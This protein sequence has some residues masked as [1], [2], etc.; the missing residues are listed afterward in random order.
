MTGPR[1]AAPRGGRTALPAASAPDETSRTFSIDGTASAISSASSTSRSVDAPK[2]VPSSAASRTASTVSGSACPN[3][4]GPHDC[5]QSRSRRPSSVSTY[6]PS[7]RA[8]KSGSS[9]PT[10]R[11]ARTGELTPPGITFCARCQRAVRT[12]GPIRKSRRVPGLEPAR[13]L[14]RPVRDH[15][16]GARP[17]DRRQRLDRRRALVDVARRSRRL[18]HRVLARHAVRGERQLEALAHRAHDVEVRQRRL[19]HQHIRALRDVELALAERL[20]DVAGIHLVP[21]AVAERRHRAGGVAKRP[22]ERRGVLG[23]VGDDR[24]VGELGSNCRDAPVHHVARTD[25]VRA[26]LHVGD[27]GARDQLERRVV[28]DLPALEDAAVA[29]RRVLAKTDVG[30]E[31]QLREPRPQRSKRLLNDAVVDP[32]AGALVVLLLGDA[33]E[34]HRLNPRPEQVLALAN[35]ALDREPRERGQPVVR[36][37]LGSD[38]QRLHEVVERQ[39]R[40][41]DEVAQGAAAAKAAETRRR[42]A[43]HL[44]S[45]RAGGLSGSAG[46]TSISTG[47]GLPPHGSSA[48]RS[49]KNSHVARPAASSGSATSAPVMPCISIPASRPKITS[50]GCRRSAPAITLGTTTWPSIWWMPMK[51]RTTQSA[52]MG[53]TTSA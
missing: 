33:E 16:V 38:E 18:E 45:V 42:E 34:D 11:I 49:E 5:T 12:S 9:R 46:S 32:R 52:E 25:G 6:A 26:G 40:L 17:T 43:G 7:P 27:S 22:V 51:R 1:R 47:S 35:G 39:R 13:E 4:S 36:Q 8:A 29:V 44:E 53:C 3:T 30:Q 14:L 31:E 2:L 20:A 28:V 19:D 10:D 24:R 41:A 23:R 48:S 37:L 15:D 50:S 21:P